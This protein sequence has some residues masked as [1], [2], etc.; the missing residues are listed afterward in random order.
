MHT[1]L[2]PGLWQISKGLWQIAS[3]SIYAYNKALQ[4]SIHLTDTVIIIICCEHLLYQKEA[5]SHTYGWASSICGHILICSQA[6]DDEV[7]L[8]EYQG[9]NYFLLIL[10]NKTNT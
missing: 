7:S 2:C 8:G 9:Y 4:L 1:P 10:D 6:D 3:M 5:H